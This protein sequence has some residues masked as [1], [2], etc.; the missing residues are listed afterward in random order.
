MRVNVRFYDAVNTIYDVI[1]RANLFSYTA[2]FMFV[3]VVSEIIK[4][5]KSDV[6][7]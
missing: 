6:E 4:I 1:K 5:N 2:K 3:S 7:R